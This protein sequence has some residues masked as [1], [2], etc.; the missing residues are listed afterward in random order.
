M[1]MQNGMLRSSQDQGTS[2]HLRPLSTKQPSQ[3]QETLDKKEIE[4]QQNRETH[5]ETYRQSFDVLKRTVERFMYDPSWDLS[6][7]EEEELSLALMSGMSG[8]AAQGYVIP[9]ECGPMANQVL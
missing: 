1:G 4:A 9:A 7:T 2:F 8:A 5:A 6:D 3:T